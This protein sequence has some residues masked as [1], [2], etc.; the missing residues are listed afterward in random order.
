MAGYPKREQLTDPAE[1]LR[2]EQ[3]SRSVTDMEVRH[4]V[5]QAPAEAS[6][7][8]YLPGIAAAATATDF[9]D[10]PAQ[11]TNLNG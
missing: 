11:W 10:P 8:F 1:V 7:H 5:L 2:Q 4:A 3:E 9:V 6:Q